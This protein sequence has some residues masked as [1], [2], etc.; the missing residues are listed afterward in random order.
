ML[1]EVITDSRYYSDDGNWKAILN[2][3]GVSK[4]WS[5]LAN[6][7]AAIPINSLD[8]QVHEIANS[9]YDSD[10]DSDSGRED[11]R[12]EGDRQEDD[13][14]DDG[15]Q[16]DEW[17]EDEWQEDEWRRDDGYWLG[18]PIHSVC[19]TLARP[20]SRPEWIRVLPETIRMAKSLYLP[21][22]TLE[23]TI[24]TRERLFRAF[25]PVMSA[26]PWHIVVTIIHG[27]VLNVNGI[28][29]FRAWSEAGK[30]NAD[31]EL[32]M[33]LAT[34]TG[35]EYIERH[36]ET[37]CSFG[38]MSREVLKYAARQAQMLA[39]PG[40]SGDQGV[41]VLG[42]LKGL[43][44]TGT[45][46]V[47][48]ITVSEVIDMVSLPRMQD[49]R[50]SG[51]RDRD[52]RDE[53]RRGAGGPITILKPRN[54]NSLNLTF[55]DCHGLSDEG[56]AT[57]L[58]A[59]PRTRTLFLEVADQESPASFT[60][61]LAKH[62]QNLEFL[63]LDTYSSGTGLDTDPDASERLLGAL[64]TMRNLRELVICRGDF[65]TAEALGDTLPPALR[66]LWIIGH[67]D[68]IDIDDRG[69]WSFN[70]PDGAELYALERH[71]NLPDLE[72]VEILPA[73]WKEDDPDGWHNLTSFPKEFR[74]LQILQRT[75]AE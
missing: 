29:G 39:Q 46:H 51:L 8:D 50:L 41:Q 21:S 45:I 53:R 38:H 36:R 48:G 9:F 68:D 42:K 64:S 22:T 14:Q 1:D 43:G 70:T 61:A 60:N 5:Q 75:A 31:A 44:I 54:M 69:D 25:L 55:T 12:R 15:G 58:A 19:Y 49:L 26:I 20:N 52:L 18:N 73:F 28:S 56:L 7:Y 35:L 23:N 40:Q 66:M 71:P 2:L 24:E 17:Q 74:Y 13:R 6:P 32:A 27:I 47:R 3:R 37:L 59:C 34:C 11:D 65:T 16:D 4:K 30:K 10:S 62:G 57:I 67:E 63:W 33:I 72:K